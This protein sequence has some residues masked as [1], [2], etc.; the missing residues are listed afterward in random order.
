MSAFVWDATGSRFYETGVNH[1]VLYPQNADGTYA[2]GVAWNGLT[3]V[4]E[5]PGGAEP[6]DL[7]ADNIKY[8]SIRSSETFGG[9]IEAYTYPDEWAE[10]DGSYAVIPGVYVGQQS[11]KPFGFCYRT[12][13]GNDTQSDEDDGYKLHIIYNATASPSEKSYETINDSPDAITLSWEISTTPIPVTNKKPTSQITI[14]STKLTETQ[15]GY[16]TTLEG[17]LYGTSNSDPTLLLPDQIISI[18]TTGSL[19]TP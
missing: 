1:G 11:R 9:T 6:N 3:G 12:E 16:L 14:D 8:A 10:C 19:P 7:Y 18:M 5:S 15:K 4:T 2:N 17:K 13:V